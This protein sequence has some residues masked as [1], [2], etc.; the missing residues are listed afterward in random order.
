MDYKKDKKDLEEHLASQMMFLEQSQKSF[1]EGYHHEAQRL[2]TT[3]RVLLHDTENSHSLLNQ[4][5]K[6]S[7]Y[8]VST[9]PP[10][11]PVN[12]ASYTGFLNIEMNKEEGSYI[13]NN[14]QEESSNIKFLEFYDWWNELIIYDNKTLF[15]R[16]DIVT[17]IANQDGGAHVDPNL[18]KEYAD[19]TKMNSL[20]WT[21]SKGINEEQKK[22]KNNAA[23]LSVRRIS[24]ELLMSLGSSELETI[25]L[26]KE[27]E[28]YKVFELTNGKKHDK[29]I[30]ITN[31]ISKEKLKIMAEKM[32]CTEE[33]AKFL[34]EKLYHNIENIEG[35]QLE[36]ES[37]RQR[38]I[39]TKKINREDVKF[40]LI[41]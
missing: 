14:I 24:E 27:K 36:K 6:K 37:R 28:Y 16:K 9:T 10:F 21:Y 2:A 7:I 20:G 17:N 12:L 11:I 18:K 23:Y 35:Y 26:I 22:L 13:L 32:S 39:L 34:F 15:T 41:K 29:T 40:N 33:R 19:L 38:Y 4:L 8:F 3:I 31:D 5:N 30:F 25:E 1:D